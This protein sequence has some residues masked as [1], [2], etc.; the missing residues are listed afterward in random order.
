MKETYTISKY[1]SIWHLNDDGAKGD[2]V[3]EEAQMAAKFGFG[4]HP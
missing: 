1:V 4:R 3:M 2:L